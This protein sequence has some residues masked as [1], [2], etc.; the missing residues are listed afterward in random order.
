[1]IAGMENRE[2][3]MINSIHLFL[4]P[5]TDANSWVELIITDWQGKQGR[6][7]ICSNSES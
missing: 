2:H 6:D 4:Q 5:P 1:M 3:K 7:A